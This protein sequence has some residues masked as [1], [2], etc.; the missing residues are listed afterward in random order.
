MAIIIWIYYTVLRLIVVLG[1]VFLDY[2]IYLSMKESV[3]FKTKRVLRKIAWICIVL[4]SL[5]IL[6]G[7]PVFSIGILREGYTVLIQNMDLQLIV[8]FYFVHMLKGKLMMYLNV[9]TAV[10]ITIYYIYRGEYQTFRHYIVAI[11]AIGLIYLSC[12]I[13]LYLKEKNVNNIGIYFISTLFYGASWGLKMYPALDFKFTGF[14]FFLANFV[15][16]MLLVRFINK[17]VRKQLARFDHLALEA[18]TDFLTGVGNRLSFDH[19]FSQRFAL[20]RSNEN[21]VFAMIDI[22]F[23]KQINDHY[24][25]D[26]G[27]IIIK[28]IVKIICQTL[29]QYQ[30]ESQ[31]FRIGG[32]EFGILFQEKS[33]Q[34]ITEILETISKRVGDF[35]LNIHGKE[36]RVTISA[37]V[38][39]CQKSDTSKEDLYKRADKYLYI[40]KREGRNAIFMEGKMLHHS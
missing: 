11:V 5:V 12:Q 31:V 28:N 23:F 33:Q 26:T 29:F 19:E 25:H 38:S 10:A 2:L 32:E 20:S 9:C 39:R 7:V 14:L 22:D 24:G 6:Q 18:R 35:S 8:L 37:G 15:L 13:V 27:D 1:V 40:A 17:L 36:V 21:L 16:L 3:F 30:M 34:D 4:I